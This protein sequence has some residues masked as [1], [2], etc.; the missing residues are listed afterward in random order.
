MPTPDGYCLVTF[1]VRHQ[2]QPV[3]FAFVDVTLEADSAIN[4]YLLSRQP[5]RA[6]TGSDGTCQIPMLQQGQ[7]TRGN[8]VYHVYAHDGCGQRFLDRRVMIPN[9]STA[10]A[11]DLQD[12]T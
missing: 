10:N 9:T 8:G 7:F 6:V 3:P 12:A 2:G 4:G 11:E 1:A 5:V